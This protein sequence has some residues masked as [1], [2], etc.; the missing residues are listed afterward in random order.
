M[1]CLFQYELSRKFKSHYVQQNNNHW[2][3]VSQLEMSEH[4][5]SSL[6]N[7]FFIMGELAVGTKVIAFTNIKQ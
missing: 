2:R 1:N 7:N 3:Y 5:N 4:M 6:E